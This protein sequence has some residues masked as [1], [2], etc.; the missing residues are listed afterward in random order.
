MS[1]ARFLAVLIPPFADTQG[2]W[3][4]Y[5]PKKVPRICWCLEQNQEYIEVLNK[6]KNILKSWTKSKLMYLQSIGHTIVLF[7]YNQ[8][9]SHHGGRVYNLS[10]T[11]VEVL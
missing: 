2:K 3:E 11:K 5:I 7:I 4:I 9:T 6:T 8:E 1:M 10:L